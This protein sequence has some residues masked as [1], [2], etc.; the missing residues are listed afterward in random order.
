MGDE[1]VCFK[2]DISPNQ[3]HGGPCI[4]CGNS[5]DKNIA[6]DGD[7]AMQVASIQAVETALS[8]FSRPA[9]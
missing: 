9:T 7:I 4:W 8:A 5:C 2:Y 3:F 1:G 6:D